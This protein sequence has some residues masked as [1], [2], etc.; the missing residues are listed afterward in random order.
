MEIF[1]HPRMIDLQHI[2]HSSNRQNT[3]IGEHCHAITDRIETIKIMG[4]QKYREPEC[5]LQLADQNI[6]RR[7]A[8]WVEACGRLVQKHDL[9]V[10]RDGA[11]KTSPF[12]HAPRQLGR[13]VG[14]RILR[15]ADHA[16]FDPCKGFAQVLVQL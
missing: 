3:F 15:Q 11:G 1:T 13:I 6:K 14:Q 7:R 16:H 4:H 12:A 9:G 10:Q 5:G 2:L 8:N